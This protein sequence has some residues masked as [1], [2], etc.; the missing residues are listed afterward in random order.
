MK[1]RISKLFL[2]ALLSI[3][4]LSACSEESSS[5]SANSTKEKADD[6]TLDVAIDATPPSL[7]PHV[8]T[9]VATGQIA[10][11]IFE[12]LVSYDENYEVQPSLAK[13]IEVSEDGKT[14]TFP[15]RDVT[16]HNGDTLT[17]ADVKASLERWG[18]ISLFGRATM[19]GVTVEAPDEKTVVLTLE[20]PSTTLLDDLAYPTGQAAYILPKSILDEAGDDVVKELVGTGPY[21]F[22]EWAQDQYIHVEKYE[23]Y[24]NPAGE[25]SGLA[26][27]KTLAYDDIFYHIVVDASTRLNGLLSGEYD[28]AKSLTTDKYDELKNNK[29]ITTTTIEPGMY[30]GLIFDTTEG[31]FSDPV[32]RQ[33]LSAAL[34]FDEIMFGAAGHKDFYRLDPGL[35]M[36]EQKKWY[37]D[38]GSDLYNKQD[39]ERAKKLFKEAGYNGETITIMTTQDYPFMYNTAIVIQDQLAKVGVKVK[40]DVF[41]WP[42]LL[43]NRADRSKWDAFTSSFPFVGQPGQTLFLYSANKHSSGYASPEMDGYLDE[44]RYASTQEEAFAAWEKAQALYWEDIPVIKF[45]DLNYLDGSRNGLTVD[46]LF[47]IEIFWNVDKK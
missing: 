41:D 9:A 20:K 10:T 14:Y 5:E 23:D 13:S 8:S 40:L 43:A 6:K 19:K 46:N 33:A 25:G 24:Q 27:A 47:G 28:Y 15:L 36:K 42:T 7:D 1:I 34:N 39:T 29:D 12:T 30:P 35:M 22:V 32:A 26:G 11:A 18:R 4:M 31:F 45:G 2:L 37:T 17:S 21:K 44:V 38:A 3:F 16:F